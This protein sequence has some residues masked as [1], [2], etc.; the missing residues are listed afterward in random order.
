MVKLLYVER[1]RHIKCLNNSFGGNV[2]WQ[3]QP[4]IQD[5]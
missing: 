3:K 5:V 1:G 2:E 4:L